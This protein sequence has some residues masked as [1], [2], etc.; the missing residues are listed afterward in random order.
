ML[1]YLAAGLAGVAWASYA[2]SKGY[3]LPAQVIIGFMIGA[4]VGCIAVV[5]E[6]L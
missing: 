5:L 2:K 3:S 4:F 6:H 1:V